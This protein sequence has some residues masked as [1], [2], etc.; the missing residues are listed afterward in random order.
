MFPSCVSKSTITTLVECDHFYPHNKGNMPKTCFHS[1][2]TIYYLG[3]RPIVNLFLL[4]SSKKSLI[5]VR[6]FSHVLKVHSDWLKVLTV[7]TVTSYW[8]W[9]IDGMIWNHKRKFFE[10]CKNR[11]F[12]HISIHWFSVN[13]Q[14]PVFESVPLICAKNG[15]HQSIRNNSLH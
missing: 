8:W 7:L 11:K 6:I 3:I 10:P 13:R 2:I 4:F 14:K 5:F 12:G 9:L 1:I 15:R